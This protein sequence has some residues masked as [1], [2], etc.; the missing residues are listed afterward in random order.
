MDI[1][2]DKKLLF[3]QLT[4]DGAYIVD[5][6]TEFYLWLGKKSD[7]N[8]RS[9]AADAAKVFFFFRISHNIIPLSFFLFSSHADFAKLSQYPLQ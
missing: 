6:D 5:C 7:N 8:L 9:V 3:E 1:T 4:T 2:Q